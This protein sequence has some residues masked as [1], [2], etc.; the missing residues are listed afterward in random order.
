MSQKCLHTSL[1][2]A[3]LWS[4]FHWLWHYQPLLVSS[5]QSLTGLFLCVFLTSLIRVFYNHFDCDCIYRTVKQQTSLRTGKLASSWSRCA[6][7][8]L[9]S[10]SV[11]HLHSTLESILDSSTSWMLASYSGAQDQKVKLAFNTIRHNNRH[12]PQSRLCL[13][14]FSPLFIIV[15][16]MSDIAMSCSL[17]STLRFRHKWRNAVLMNG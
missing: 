16:L 7:L 5:L 13:E 3:L 9:F 8:S 1:P 15:S 12:W 17:N 6:T 4:P 2:W 14:W 10:L 11:R